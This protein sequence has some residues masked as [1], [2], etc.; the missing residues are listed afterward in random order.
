MRASLP[1]P[2]TG[3]GSWTLTPAQLSG[4][5]LTLADDTD[6]SIDLNVTATATETNGDT[7]SVSKSLN[8]TINNAP[9][10][11]GD[12]VVS[13][14]DDDS[15]VIALDISAPTDPDGDNL[16]IEITALPDNGYPVPCRRH[17]R[18]DHG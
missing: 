10:V 16:T 12:K 14:A 2:T 3:D 18:H 17:G 11:E 9:T 7:A 8:I 4:L 13:M 1:G 15:A 6:R 5:S